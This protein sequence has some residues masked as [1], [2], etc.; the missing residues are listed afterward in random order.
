MN[1]RT[2]VE[3]FARLGDKGHARLLADGKGFTGRVN[4]ADYPD[5]A[6]YK[7]RERPERGMCYMNAQ[8]FCL[9]NEGYEYYEGYW[10]GG[11]IPVHHGWLVR[12]GKVIDFT[13]EACDVL[14][15]EWGNYPSPSENDYFGVRIDTDFIRTCIL[16]THLWEPI[17][18]YWFRFKDTGE[19]PT[20][21]EKV[22]KPRKSRKKKGVAS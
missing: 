1:A 9:Y 4:T 15:A 17:S 16:A 2:M 7:K 8:R 11:I 6:E 14:K 12:D 22:S 18:G 21:P 20:R 3:S 10:H 5:L 13:A 19:V